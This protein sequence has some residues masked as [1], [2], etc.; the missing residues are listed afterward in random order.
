MKS[1]LPPRIRR[2]EVFRL[3]KAH[4]HLSR[5]Q[6]FRTKNIATK[7]EAREAQ[8]V[9]MAEETDY[10][11]WSHENLIE[12]VTQLEQ[13]LKSKNQTSEVLSVLDCK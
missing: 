8:R 4:F 5:R 13:A 6:P 10:R 3:S 12:R 2:L 7:V 9:K 1:Y 11:T